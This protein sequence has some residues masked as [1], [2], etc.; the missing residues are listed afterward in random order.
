MLKPASSSS[1]AQFLSI[2]GTDVT[3]FRITK[4]SSSPLPTA[5]E[6]YSSLSLSLYLFYLLSLAV[7]SSTDRVDIFKV[8]VAGLDVS[9]EL[10]GDRI[11]SHH[12]LRRDSLHHL[13]AL[14]G[15]PH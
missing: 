9:E 13:L 10:F 6:S 12:V 5:S 1:L 8:R 3:K 15:G 2:T 14:C 4:L 7:N 11:R